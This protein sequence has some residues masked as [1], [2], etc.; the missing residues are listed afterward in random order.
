M[1]AAMKS[2][3]KA[4]LSVIRMILSDM[5]YAQSATNVHTELDD[6]TAAKVVASYHKKLLK[7]L[8]EFPAGDQRTAL[9]EEIRVVE[10]YMPKRA[11]E[12]DVKAAVDA[13]MGS[14]AERNFGVLMKLT[15]E[16][17][18]GAADG[19][20]VSQFIKQKLG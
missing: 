9:E 19:K 3:E 2:G 12:D 15:M 13:V 6:A 17:L 20:L 5:K 16:K 14:T 11:S 10:G 18:G 4:K 7:S 1:K 8:D